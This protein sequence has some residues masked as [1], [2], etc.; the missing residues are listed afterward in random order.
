MHPDNVRCLAV[1]GIDVC[2]LANNHTLDFGEAGPLETMDTLAGVGVRSVG[3]GCTL[4]EAREPARVGIPGEGR[5][6]VFAF[7]DESSGIPPGWTAGDDRPGL[8][9]L[10]DL[11]QA[12]ARGVLE[13]FRAAALRA[14]AA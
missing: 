14:V 2:S 12:T 5:L 9:V 1:A 13:R 6:L 3:A 7:G 4:A 10:P 11:S 8:D